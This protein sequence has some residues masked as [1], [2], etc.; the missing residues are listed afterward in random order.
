MIL[1]DMEMPKSCYDCKLNCSF[2]MVAFG[3][4]REHRHPNCPLKEIPKLEDAPTV[5]RAEVEHDPDA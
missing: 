2:S 3:G 1:I 5:I 4:W